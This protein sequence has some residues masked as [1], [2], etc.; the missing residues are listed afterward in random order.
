MKHGKASCLIIANGD[1]QLV[2]ELQYR[3][4]QGP[5]EE[6]FWFLKSLEIHEIILRAKESTLTRSDG[7]RWTLGRYGI[8]EDLS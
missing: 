6:S 8:R 2:R 5:V 4:V 3:L 7:I 1:R